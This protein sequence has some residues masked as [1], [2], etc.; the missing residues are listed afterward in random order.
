MVLG[1]ERFKIVL[2]VGVVSLLTGLLAVPAGA[3]TNEDGNQYTDKVCD[4]VITIIAGNNANN[5]QNQ[6]AISGDDTLSNE[7]TQGTTTGN[8]IVEN[9]L[10]NEDITGDNVN[11]IAQEL[12]ISP[13]IVQNCIEGNDNEIGGRDDNGDDTNG[14]ADENGVI[15]IP[16]GNLP[17]TGGPPLLA[18]LF[19]VV[20]GAG[21]LTALVRRR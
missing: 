15:N 2:A 11:E 14:D 13:T 7:S 12:N 9:D 19:S 21:L 16:D 4:A 18:I 8:N 17:N 20:A 3:Q 6:E 1:I 10:N 5:E